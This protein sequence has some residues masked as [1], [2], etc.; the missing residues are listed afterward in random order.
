MPTLIL[1]KL[2]NVPTE[3][4]PIRLYQLGVTMKGRPTMKAKKKAA[5]KPAAKK[6]AAKKKR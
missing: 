5:K 6:K 1:T 2:I 4:S 3:S